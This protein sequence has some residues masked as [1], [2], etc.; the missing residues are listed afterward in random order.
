MQWDLCNLAH[1]HALGVLS[2]NQTMIDEALTYFSEGVGNGRLETAIWKL[3][4][5]DGT[6]KSLGQNQEAGRDQGHALLD[7][8]LLGP[9]AQQSYNQGEDLFALLDNRILAG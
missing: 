6:G 9:F 7:F 4:E 2:D 8:A 1:V 5:E 3:Y